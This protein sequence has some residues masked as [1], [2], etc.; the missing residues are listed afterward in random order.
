MIPLDRACVS[1]S[2][3]LGG[4][5]WRMCNAAADRLQ[6]MRC[7][8]WSRHISCQPHISHKGQDKQQGIDGI[9]R[10]FVTRLLQAKAHHRV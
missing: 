6:K 4:E 5:P 10:C 3:G 2:L 8:R 1:A 7:A 9:E